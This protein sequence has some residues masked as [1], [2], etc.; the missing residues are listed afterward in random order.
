MNKEEINNNNNQL[1]TNIIHIGIENNNNLNEE[2]NNINISTNR[3]NIFYENKETPIYFCSNSEKRIFLKCYGPESCAFYC[4]LLLFIIPIGSLNIFAFPKIKKKIWK[5]IN[6]IIGDLI[7]LITLFSYFNVVTSSPGYEDLNKK[8]TKNEYEEINPVIKIKNSTFKLKYCETCQIIRHLRSF[9]CKYCN[10]CILRQDHHCAYV[11]NCIG[12]YN[13]LKFLIFLICV[14]FYCLY[15]IIFCIVLPFKEK[16]KNLG[17][18]RIIY[19]IV[20]AL[21]AISMF[22]T[23]VPFTFSHI[24]LISVNKTTREDIKNELYDNV[25]NN[26]CCENWKDV[27]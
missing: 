1:N 10:K 23:M 7:M 8:I 6:F 18:G 19:L 9:H 4:T 13:H 20:F 21:F 3:K 5:I 14:D 11:N 15:C 25:L 17:L 2:N 27:C 22:L 16:K 24:Y 12:K 26:G